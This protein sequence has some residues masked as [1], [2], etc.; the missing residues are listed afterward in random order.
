MII[1]VDELFLKNFIITYIIILLSAKLLNRKIKLYRL[2]LASLISSI[3]SIF[4]II[5]DANNI[6][7][8]MLT[9]IL[10]SDI[11]YATQNLFEKISEVLC[12]V[13]ITLLIG[14]TS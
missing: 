14:R 8:K 11:A 4:L 3:I 13:I 9:L 10:L 5:Y 2:I 6:Y 7:T 1:Y 12:I